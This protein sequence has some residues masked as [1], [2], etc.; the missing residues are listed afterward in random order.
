M[1][2]IGG[3]YRSRTL[4]TLPGLHTRPTPDRLRETLFDILASRIEGAVFADVY[5]G[6]GSVGIEALSRGARESIFIEKNHAA[7][8]VIRQ[9]LRALGL[10][11]RAQVICGKAG[12]AIA[13][14][15]PD[16]VFLDPPYDLENEYAVVLGALGAAPP[17][18]AIAQHTV[19]FPLPVEYGEL[20]RFRQVKQGD[21]I[22]SFFHRSHRGDAENAETAQRDST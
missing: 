4:K 19:R 13:R 21:N 17:A 11:A 16:I 6:T 18:L 5:A 12:V 3:E 22:L 10:E 8:D 7:V 20:S 9:N 15:K 14:L 1:R 2:V